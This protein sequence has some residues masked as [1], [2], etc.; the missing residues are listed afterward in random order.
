MSN[1]EYVGIGCVV[2]KDTSAAF[3]ADLKAV[4]KKYNIAELDI[5]PIRGEV[6]R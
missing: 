6:R 3:Y 5:K 4:A 1:V 2:P